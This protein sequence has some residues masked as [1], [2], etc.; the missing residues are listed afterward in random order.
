VEKCITPGG[1]I[2]LGNYPI[3]TSSRRCDADQMLLAAGDE[4][5]GR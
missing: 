3:I 5:D 4:L 1:A 2:L